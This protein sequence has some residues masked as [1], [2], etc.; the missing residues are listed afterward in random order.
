MHMPIYYH[1]LGIL[2]TVMKT[3]TPVLTRG[4]SINPEWGMPK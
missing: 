4:F 3:K 1:P 2:N